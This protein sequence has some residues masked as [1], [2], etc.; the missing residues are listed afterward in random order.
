M[1]VQSPALRWTAPPHPGPRS[2]PTDAAAPGWR[3]RGGGGNPQFARREEEGGGT[4]RCA[5]GRCRAGGDSR[6]PAGCGGGSGPPGCAL[7]PAA[8]PAALPGRPGLGA[9][10]SLAASGRS[11]DGGG[12]TGGGTCGGGG[13]RQ[14]SA[15]RSAP[16]ARPGMTR[17]RPGGG[18]RW[19]PAALAALLALRGE[20]CTG[21]AGRG[22]RHG[23]SPCGRGVAAAGGTAVPRA[24]GS[25][26]CGP[27]GD[28]RECGGGR[29][30]LQAGV[31]KERCSARLL[32]LPPLHHS[33]YY[34]YIYIFYLIYFLPCRKTCLKLGFTL[35]SVVWA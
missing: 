15:A 28:A 24:W 10:R 18:G 14:G 19:V 33:S 22:A 7:G 20:C 26:D 8:A 13:E 29:V 35:G 34:S 2:I 11:R 12:T 3:G 32:L 23:A 1:G 6:S 25:F 17:R 21:G 27:A 30:L 16:L 5:P 31:G 4:C 9:R